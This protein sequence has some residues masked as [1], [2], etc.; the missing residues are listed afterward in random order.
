M[1]TTT[2]IMGGEEQRMMMAGPFL[3]GQYDEVKSTVNHRPEDKTGLT[4]V[5]ILVDTPLM[6]DQYCSVPTGLG[7]AVGDQV[8]IEYASRVALYTVR[9]ITANHVVR[10]NGKNRLGIPSSH[11]TATLQGP[12]V[13]CVRRISDVQAKAESEI[14]ERLLDYHPTNEGFIIIAPHGGDIDLK[15]DNQAEKVHAAIE[16]STLWMCK[17]Y[18][19]G[20]GAFRQWHV[21]SN[22]ISPSSFPL[23]KS[24]VESNRKFVRCVAFHGMAE[25]GVLIGGLGPMHVKLALQ[26]AIVAHIADETVPVRLATWQ[27]CCNGLSSR[28]IVNWMTKKGLGGIQIEQDRRVRSRYWRAVADAVIEVFEAEFSRPV[29]GHEE[30]VSGLFDD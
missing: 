4:T 26:K 23:L 29:D 12:V 27:D 22:D 2:A 28:N 5:I 10:L 25:G 18:W 15:T 6:N 16:G 21:T 24:L 17:G 19:K 3:D 13:T 14:V 7:I 8:R 11:V 9:W 20:G 1:T 30:F